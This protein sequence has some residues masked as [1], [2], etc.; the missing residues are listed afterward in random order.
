MRSTPSL[1]SA[2]AM[3]EFLFL[4]YANWRT[5]LKF[6]WTGS[7]PRDLVATSRREL[8]PAWAPM[9]DQFVYVT[10]RRGDEEIWLSSKK[11]GWQRPLVS[12]SDLPS[13]T[14]Y[15]FVA[16]VWSPDGSRIAYSAGG[17]VW[18]SSIAGG[19]AT[20]LVA[21][22]LVP[23]WSPD[24]SWIGFVELVGNKEYLCKQ[25]VGS[26]MPP[27]R[28]NEATGQFRP[29]WSPDGKWITIQLP[30]GFGLI[31]PD[32][33][34]KKIIFRGNLGVGSACGWSRDPST[35]YL[36]YVKD[37]NLILS[38]F[39]VQTGTEKKISNLGAA[40][41]SYFSGNS[42]LLNEAP[43]GKS[44]AGSFLRPDADIWMIEGVQPPPDF[45]HRLVSLPTRAQ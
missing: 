6:R 12:Q 2:R 7:A 11:E 20:P 21:S 9:G 19:P 29:A 38:A 10:D 36:G 43:D 37:Q 16:P 22:G 32:G 35:L 28:I 13:G 44:L 4:R 25:K 39:N 8:Y 27:V 45:W 30:E 24:G 14:R 42:L 1:R 31:S 18:I 17:R 5:L 15:Q 33:K 3:G 40:R 34:E 41:F 23:T 26:S